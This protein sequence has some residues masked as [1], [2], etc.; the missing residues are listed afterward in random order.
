MCVSWALGTVWLSLRI[1]PCHSRQCRG[2]DA[3][4]EVKAERRLTGLYVTV[5]NNPKLH[6]SSH[7]AETGIR[8]WLSQ[9]PP[10]LGLSQ[11]RSRCGPGLQ[12]VPG[13][14]GPGVFP[15]EVALRS[16]PQGPLHGAAQDTAAGSVR[17]NKQEKPEGAD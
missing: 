6:V 17:R 13:S 8:V 9:M 10:A 16:Q 2:I 1:T 11:A 4:L 12:P 3:G 5:T 14:V 7:F 15:R